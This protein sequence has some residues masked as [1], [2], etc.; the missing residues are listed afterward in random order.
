MKHAQDTT[1]L[2]FRFEDDGAIPN[3]QTFPMLIY[4]HALTPGDEAKQIFHENN[5]LDTWKGSVDTHHHYHSNSHE[6]L[7]VVS[8][9]AQLQLG[10]QRRRADTGHR[11]V[12]R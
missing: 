10:G 4:K 9:W 7:A 8:G 11:S 12:V 1:I 3:S 5:W 6:V 2:T